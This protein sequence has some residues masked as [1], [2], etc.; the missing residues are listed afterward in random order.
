MKVLLVASECVPFSKTGGLADVVGALP[1]ALKKQGVDARVI[2]PLYRTMHDQWRSKLEHVLFFYV[3]LGWRRQYVGIEKL[4][5]G[6]VTYYF[7]DNEYYFGRSY[8]YGMGGDEG[9]RFAFFCRAVLEALA[10]IDFMP[11]VL[12]LNDWQTGL[13]A[14]MLEVQ[15]RVLPPYRQVK[16]VF[17]VHN[18]Q[19]QGV[20]PI[21]EIEDLVALGPDMYQSDKLEFYGQCSF[22]KA[23]LTY[24]DKITTVSPSYVEEIQTAY[25]G[26]KLD[27]LLRARS[28]DL[29][30]ILNGIDV[31]EYNPETD[32]MIEAR[33]GADT[34]DHKADNKLA[35]Q[36]EL[37]L[38]EGADI[39]MIA[40]V[41]RLSGQKGLDLVD[42][43]LGG[44]MKT[45]AQLVVLGMGEDRYV[46]LFSW[47][48]WK[49]A[50][51]L[52]A[53]VEMNAPLAHRIY[54]AADM[55]LM[56]SMF[57]PCGLSQMIALRYGT[58]P[59]VRET[60]G[61]RDTVLSYNEY[62]GEG[63]GFTFFNYNAHDMLSVIER[64]VD[65]YKNHP[66]VWR[67]LM[68]RAMNGQYGW[69]QS[70]LNYAELY[71][72]LVGVAVPKPRARKPKAGPKAEAVKAAPGKKAPANKAEAA[73]EAA[74]AAPKPRKPRA[75]KAET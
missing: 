17:T 4:V 68:T 3:N 30:G 23:G 31:D 72:Q 52:A 75:K 69:D 47:G 36:R 5:E 65:H 29:H 35:L 56:P 59:I 32:P 8:I 43:V 48:Q 2:S 26:E 34:L 18:L 66:D 25:Y 51:S 54:A 15:Y 37:G 14:P 57:E 28:A 62:T 7:I 19:Y 61:L 10:Q 55:F 40:M 44:I 70:A 50:G 49:Y 22:M 13:I 24:A 11:D 46:D 9:E 64:A 74:P 33:Y 58:L 27:G 38:N 41:T 53:R 42:R 71:A 39:P 60:G 20:F 73:K 67:M 16:T 45:G 63:N 21:G 12:H 6:D 1:R